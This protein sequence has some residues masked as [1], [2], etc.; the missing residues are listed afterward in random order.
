MSD[1]T[2]SKIEREARE[3]YEASWT[4]KTNGKWQSL[5]GPVRE[6]WRRQARL[7]LCVPNEADIDEL[8]R[9]WLADGC[10]DIEDTE[11]CEAYREELLAWRLGIEAERERETTE[12][13]AQRSLL[14]RRFGI[15]RWKDAVM[16][17]AIHRSVPDAVRLVDA[18]LVEIDRALTE[19][20]EA[21]ERMAE[22]R[23]AA[24]AEVQS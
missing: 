12:E 5:P 4:S 17:A 2:E 16:T 21:E 19:G 11:G 18:A 15:E 9:P 6:Q 14:R 24:K 3:T 1:V 13:L 8:K 7:A 20:I 10:W 22:L 23:A